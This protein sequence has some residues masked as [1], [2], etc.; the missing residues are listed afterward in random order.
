MPIVNDTPV[1]IDPNP[2]TGGRDYIS[3]EVFE[4]SVIFNKETNAGTIIQEISGLPWSVRMIA[5]NREKHTEA[6][7]PDINLGVDS[8]SYFSITDLVIYLDSSLPTTSVSDL[9]AEATINAGYVPSYGDVIIATLSGGREAMFVITEVRKDSYNNHDIYK[10]FF[11]I[12]AFLDQDPIFYNDLVLKT[13]K[14]FTYNRDFV[15]GNGPPLLLSSDFKRKVDL[16][17]EAP[18]LLDHYM[19]LFFDAETSTLRLPTESYTFVDTM[20]LDTVYAVVDR[21]EHL[22]LSRLSHVYHH[23]TEEQTIWDVIIKQDI[24]LLPTVNRKLGFTWSPREAMAVARTP[25]VLGVA[26]VVSV[27]TDG[28]VPYTVKHNRL[29][30]A[31]EVTQPV[32]TTSPSYIF[33]E[34]FY[35][36]EQANVTEFEGLLLQFLRKEVLD[37]LALAKVLGEYKY[38]GYEEQYYCLPILLLFIKHNNNNL[39]SNL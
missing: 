29:M 23:V 14:E 16:K 7:Y 17:L 32:D 10:V 30:D 24:D 22:D 27:V 33:S 9:T 18:K 20:L 5:Q 4:T 37:H 15:S 28:P 35:N 36:N 2:V 12:H 39:F 1:T 38:W 26:F 8:L 6:L 11:K 21:S 34:A 25:L 3:Q 31:K 19:R 13:V